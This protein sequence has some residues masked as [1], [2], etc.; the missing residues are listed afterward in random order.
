MKWKYPALKAGMATRK[1]VT[2]DNWATRS[3][4]KMHKWG[5]KNQLGRKL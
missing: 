4:E 1:H 2:K 5:V 3:V